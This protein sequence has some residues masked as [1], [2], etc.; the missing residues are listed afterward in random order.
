MTDS[1][2]TTASFTIEAASP[3][4][5]VT[6]DSDFIN[7][8]F[9][10]SSGTVSWTLDVNGTPING[11]GNIAQTWGTSAVRVHRITFSNPAALTDI[12]N[13]GYCTINMFRF[14][15]GSAFTSNI[16][17]QNYPSRVLDWDVTGVNIRFVECGSY[18]NFYPYTEG[19][20]SLIDAC[21]RSGVT[22]GTMFYSLPPIGYDYANY[23]TLFT[24]RGWTFNGVGGRC[25]PRP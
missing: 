6:T 14:V 19:L 13:F 2:H 18:D 10:L 21:V 3:Y 5:E 25:I 8:N 22:G 15:N 12:T 1:N 9:T 24:T 20:N 4:I 7:M 16:R 17:L 23:N 11:T